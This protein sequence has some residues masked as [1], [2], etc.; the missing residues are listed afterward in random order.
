LIHQQDLH[1]MLDKDQHRV[2][3]SIMVEVCTPSIVSPM[4]QIL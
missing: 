2:M 1:P 4:Y 3:Q